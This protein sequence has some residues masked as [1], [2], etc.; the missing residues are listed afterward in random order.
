MFE[1]GQSP[2]TKK[3]QGG[4][5]PP[6]KD[7]IYLEP[8]S[9]NDYDTSTICNYKAKIKGGQSPPIANDKSHNVSFLAH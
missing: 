1:G 5:S 4:Q 2:P 9:A 8:T 3:N 7:R 6:R